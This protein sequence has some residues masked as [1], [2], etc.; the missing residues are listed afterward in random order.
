M[1][2]SSVITIVSV[3][4]SMSPLERWER[5][6]LEAHALAA[7]AVVDAWKA[8]RASG[9]AV[10]RAWIDGNVGA[11]WASGDPG[12]DGPYATGGARWSVSLWGP[13][14]R[15]RLTASSF[16]LDSFQIA[17]DSAADASEELARA[18]H[19]YIDAWNARRK[20]SLALSFLAGR[21][22]A[23]E[24]L[25]PRVR[26]GIV[27]ES[28][29]LEFLTAFLA[30]ER[31]TAIWNGIVRAADA[32]ASALDSGG[33]VPDWSIPPDLP[34]P[35]DDS[36]RIPAFPVVSGGS[37]FGEVDVT[38]GLAASSSVPVEGMASS[39]LRVF[40]EARVPLGGGSDVARIRTRSVVVAAKETLR[41]RRRRSE[42][43]R[44]EQER[45]ASRI[46]LKYA[47]SRCEA[48]SELEREAELRA[49]AVA[50]EPLERLLHARALVYRAGIERLDAQAACLHRDVDLLALGASSG[51]RIITPFASSGI[52]VDSAMLPGLGRR[53]ELRLLAWNA[54]EALDAVGSQATRLRRDGI[55]SIALSWSRGGIDSLGLA[56]VRRALLRAMGV[57]RSEGV[58]VDLL[59]GD[60]SWL[61]DS[62]R[63]GM[64]SV[65]EKTVGLPF[66]RLV[67]DLEPLQLDTSRLP[68][69]AW[70][71]AFAAAGR[72][73]AGRN[74]PVE[75]ILQ[76]S[77]ALECPRCLDSLRSSGAASLSAM[78]YTRSGGTFLDR[79]RRFLSAGE[80]IPMRVV[81]SVE[82]PPVLAADESL[83]FLGRRGIGAFL[84]SAARE[85]SDRPRFT[86][87]DIQSFHD[88]REVA[89]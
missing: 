2:V 27:L 25:A 72:I 5:S 86:G 34:E 59:L 77:V 73:A 62:E 18:R 81:V 54:A 24:I 23:E 26:R 57:Y 48:A 13:A 67:L 51:T 78:L 71:A 31:D 65:L 28:D 64:R 44:A 46:A 53:R 1:M 45:A 4:A 29:R 52:P 41:R 16:A 37:G 32:D 22:R 82:A 58:S 87:F 9:T 80:E 60:P 40:L 38:A 21:R 66:R 83:R 50:L 14:Q 63:E 7:R 20:L 43:A 74:L 75:W 85:L 15:A 70:P 11:G 19:L 56:E 12:L 33:S 39:D 49:G 6:V 36:A 69:G 47:Q 42:L 35:R 17:Q 30:T 79:S 3:I 84:D 10:R 88:W 61:L 89:P 76:P 55:G 8:D 68:R